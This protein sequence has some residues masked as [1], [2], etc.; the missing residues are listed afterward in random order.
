MCR[1]WFTPVISGQNWTVSAPKERQREGECNGV[2]GLHWICLFVC[3][4]QVNTTNVRT[5]DISHPLSCIPR[6][7]RLL[8][9]SLCTQFAFTCHFASSSGMGRC[10]PGCVLFCCSPCPMR[11]LDSK[12]RNGCSTT[13]T[14]LP[15]RLVDAHHGNSSSLTVQFF[16]PSFP[17][18]L[19]CRCVEMPQTT[20]SHRAG[21]TSNHACRPT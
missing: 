13:L 19:S 1:D 11:Q 5:R 15:S 14:T 9:S 16:L 6:S 17:R 21:S 8:L 7:I 12:H 18:V 4:F 10:L 3:W 20:E 2:I